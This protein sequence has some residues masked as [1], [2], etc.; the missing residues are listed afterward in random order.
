MEKNPY[1]AMMEKEAGG[2][3][4]AAAGAIPGV[5]TPAAAP[6]GWV[7][8]PEI[9]LPPAWPDG[10]DNLADGPAPGSPYVPPDGVNPYEAMVEKVAD[11]V[12]LNE[13]KKT[14]A[15]LNTIQR[16]YDGEAPDMGTKFV[17]AFNG[18][19]LTM[20]NNQSDSE[21]KAARK[22]YYGFDDVPDWAADNYDRL[23]EAAGFLPDRNPEYLRRIVKAAYGDRAELKHLD[24]YD[25]PVIEFDTGEIVPFTESEL[26]WQAV[27][28]A[29]ATVGV[30]AAEA[31]PGIV[32][33]VTGGMPGAVGGVGA[34]AFAG[35]YA[36]LEN[37]S[38][39]GF[40]DMTKVE[41]AGQAAYHALISAGLEVGFIGVGG[42]VR[43]LVQSKVGIMLLGDLTEEEIELVI[44][45]A[46]DLHEETGNPVT[47]GQAIQ[48]S[49]VDGDIPGQQRLA[50]EVRTVEEDLVRSGD[51]DPIRKILKDQ[52]IAAGEANDA[53]MERSGVVAA[54]TMEAATDVG[55][56]V[57]GAA[58]G[59]VEAETAR[60]GGRAVAVRET[61]TE[62]IKA[63]TQAPDIYVN[64]EGVR[65]YV[66]TATRE[67]FAQLSKRY[68]EFWAQ[69]PEDTPVD[70]APL[71]DVAA[72]YKDRIEK[73]LL[74]K[75]TE[76]D[77]PII[78]EALRVGTEGGK[79]I[80]KSSRLPPIAVGR[81]EMDRPVKTTK[82]PIKEVGVIMESSTR[83]ITQLK[84]ELRAIASGNSLNKHQAGL[85]NKFAN[86]LDDAR[87][88]ALDGLDPD[89]RKQLT[90]INGQYRE[91][92]IQIYGS[93][94]NK[95]IKKNK[96]GG[97]TID[98]TK[99]IESLAGNPGTLRKLVQMVGS[100]E[101]AGFGGTQLFKDGMLRLYRR[102]VVN[103]ENPI[104][105]ASFMDN[106]QDAIDQIFTA[107][108][109]KKIFKSL[110]TAHEHI[111]TAAK[112][113]ADEIVEMKQQFNWA[114]SRWD[115]EHVFKNTKGDLANMRKVKRLLKPNSYKWNEYQKL[116]ARDFVNE[117]QVK[118]SLGMKMFSP[119]K[120]ANYIENHTPE[121]RLMLGDEYIADLKW[122]S[123]LGDIS[124]M[125]AR[126][127]SDLT[128]LLAETG[129]AG[130]AMMTWRAS[131]ARP[132]S[133]MGLFTT[134]GVKITR[135][136]ARAALVK[137]LENPEMLRT[138]HQ[139]YVK[140]RPLAA[141]RSF[142]RSIGFNEMV[143]QLGE[144]E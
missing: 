36:R 123:R 61:Q 85:L 8:L 56:Q 124:I 128:A 57:G 9:N 126:A 22:D 55:H 99:V 69:V 125:P 71:R 84:A 26:G 93:Y 110:R 3:G 13:P 132:L 136:G 122:V 127:P 120:I 42:M 102:Q 59:E 75:L 100:D 51:G 97:Y 17:P 111:E 29:R 47:T 24:G 39:A 138:L 52:E 66:E 92:S 64:A 14:Y 40:H 31:A 12:G 87:M 103:S 105:H 91:A 60:I 135:S 80:K 25:E 37:S 73:D 77:R 15:P 121:L 113:E 44:K 20:V 74:P 72:E 54:D 114:L 131:V 104:T 4:I 88:K 67:T 19:G 133:R 28:G 115:A 58:R 94:L 76:E 50:S 2:G 49:V 137:V 119:E 107:P 34:G 83:T 144:R 96:A 142:F 86:A 11:T 1:E 23:E 89:L 106:Y 41:M 33:A 129:V 32:G 98:E 46:S 82:T 10:P 101:Y 78:E 53:A 35:E 45:K 139:M 6:D 118:D 43:R 79:T 141:W 5:G 116:W 143:D 65:K 134:A 62:V 27:R 109:R 112:K 108:E 63:T 21:F 70:V 140:D 30:I 18:L 7:T 81:G 90:E 117:I 130:P 95:I 16:E 48:Q 68:E 38:D